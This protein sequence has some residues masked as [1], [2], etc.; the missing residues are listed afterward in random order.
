MV[1]KYSQDQNFA[2][3]LIKFYIQ[4]QQYEKAEN[5]CLQEIK[6]MDHIEFY[7]L[8]IEIYQ[9]TQQNDKHMKVYIQLLC[10]KYS[11]QIQYYHQLKEICPSQQWEANKTRSDS[12]FRKAASQSLCYLC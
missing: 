3:E 7:K 11:G 9:Q 8:L 2:I 12:L 4:V 10:H 5:M 1:K 6:K